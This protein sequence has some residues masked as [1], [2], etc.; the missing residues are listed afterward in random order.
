MASMTVRCRLFGDREAAIRGIAAR[1][2]DPECRAAR[3]ARLAR[4]LRRV[5]EPLLACRDYSGWLLDCENCRAISAQ[6]R[7]LAELIIRKMAGFPA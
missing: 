7:M 4:E 5:T 3:T 2:N 6:R 1:L